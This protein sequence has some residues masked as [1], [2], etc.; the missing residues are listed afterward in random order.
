MIQNKPLFIKIEDFEIVSKSVDD[1]K[2]RTQ[3]IRK[4][5]SELKEAKKME[6]DTLRLWEQRIES[7]SEKVGQV[8][9]SLSS[10]K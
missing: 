6:D 7:L 3:R 10:N 8:E 1:I 5:L 4:K 2:E 9:M